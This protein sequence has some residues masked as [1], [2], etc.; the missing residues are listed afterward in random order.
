MGSKR[1]FIRMGGVFVALNAYVWFVFVCVVQPSMTEF[2][3][4]L[5][6]SSFATTTPNNP[7]SLSFNSSPRHAFNLMFFTFSVTILT[8]SSHFCLTA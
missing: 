6:L 7:A 5:L 3:Q 2:V 8:N 1:F 4:S